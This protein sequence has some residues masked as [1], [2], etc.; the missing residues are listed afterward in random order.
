MEGLVEREELLEAEVRAPLPLEVGQQV[1]DHGVVQRRELDGLT[2]E[3]R[4]RD[5]L[6]V[7]PRDERADL[8][9]H[10]D[11]ALVRQQDQAF[12]HRRPADAEARG[13]L[14]PVEA[15][16]VLESDDVPVA[17][18]AALA[19]R[20]ASGGPD[21]RRRARRGGAGQG[22]ADPRG[23]GRSVREC[24]ATATAL[25]SAVCTVP[26]DREGIPTRAELAASDLAVVR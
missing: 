9:E 19:A 6:R 22:R 2:Q 20:L 13:R 21:R 7:D 24:L 16:P 17:E 23:A 12:A 3:P 4:V 10:L 11:Q 15:A 26:G 5:A 1:P 8:R 18:G 25:G 14:V